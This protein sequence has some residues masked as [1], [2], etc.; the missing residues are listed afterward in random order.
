MSDTFSARLIEQRQKKGL[1]QAQLAN[2]LD[3]KRSTISGY[4][5]E[6]KEPDFETLCEFAEFFG[7]STDYLLGLSNIPG[8]RDDLLYGISDRIKGLFLLL[9]SDSRDTVAKAYEEF[10]NILYEDMRLACSDQLSQSDRL[11]TYVD[12]FKTI[13]DSR[14]EIKSLVD[15]H[16][17]DVTDLNNLSNILKAQNEFKH[18]VE[19][20]LDRLLE[21]DINIALFSDKLSDSDEN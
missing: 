13:A 4:E 19:D 1:T 3:R 12:F 11:S 10:Y 20:L 16:G 9:S 15:R 14:K 6:G 8:N 7:V 5:T 17:S 18:K 21:D 2:L